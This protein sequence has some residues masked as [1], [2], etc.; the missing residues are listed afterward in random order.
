MVNLSLG[1]A[2]AHYALKRQSVNRQYLILQG[3]AFIS[4]YIEICDEDDSSPSKAE[5]TYNIGRL[6]HLLGIPALAMRYYS[7]AASLASDE[8][9]GSKDISILSVTNQI[10][11]LLSL[12]NNDAA[13]KL[14][15]ENAVL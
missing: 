8:S 7:E 3:F 15:K 9:T 11:S 6:Y 14:L 13:L 5:M 10:V 1:L 12:G 2:Y 4:Q